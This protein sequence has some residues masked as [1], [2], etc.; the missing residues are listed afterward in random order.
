MP[1]S[2]KKPARS[3][4]VCNHRGTLKLSDCLCVLQ[5]LSTAQS[6]GAF[7]SHWHGLAEFVDLCTKEPCSHFKRSSL[8]HLW[9][10]VCKASAKALQL[11]HSST[12]SFQ[13]HSWEVLLGVGA[14][15]E[16]LHACVKV[17]STDF[18][19]SR[20]HGSKAQ[21]ERLLAAV[22]AAGGCPTGQPYLHAQVCSS[23]TS[24]A[25]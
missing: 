6:T 7:R 2:S 24:K 14:L 12:G 1:R 9:P 5:C 11:L 4:T 16:S 13:H 18:D 20:L 8:E 22:T 3:E 23:S 21:L 25:F 17:A 10:G 15:L 19:P